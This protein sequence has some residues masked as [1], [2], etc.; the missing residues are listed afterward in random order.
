MRGVEKGGG[1]GSETGS[2]MKKKGKKLTTGIG[3]SLTRTKGIKRKA[4]SFIV[5]LSLADRSKCIDNPT[6]Q[7]S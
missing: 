1:D 7:S 6:S 2:V 3:A 5:T 4:T